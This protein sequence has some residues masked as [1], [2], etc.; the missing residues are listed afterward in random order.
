MAISGQWHRSLGSRIPHRY[1]ETSNGTSKA[2]IAIPKED[3]AEA[4]LKREQ[5]VAEARKSL[6][7]HPKPVIDLFEKWLK[8]AQVALVL[9]EDHGY[10]IDVNAVYRVRRIFLEFGRRFCEMDLFD[11]RT[12]VMFL[13]LDEIVDVA[14][15]TIERDLRT[16]VASRKTDFER[17]RQMKPPD[18]LGSAPKPH[19]EKE[20]SRTSNMFFGDPPACFGGSKRAQRHLGIFRLR[21]GQSSD[22][23]LNS[24]R[25]GSRARGDHRC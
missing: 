14:R 19:P 9:S 8:A 1:L 7:R 10:W 3:L 13:R 23:E 12:D 5:A 6:E 17:Y 24:R 18:Q 4:A 20:R 21:Q 11:E 25:R 16:I 15:S 22:H 2:K